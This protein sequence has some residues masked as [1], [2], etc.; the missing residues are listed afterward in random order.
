MF[1]IVIERICEPSNTKPI[2]K[3]WRPHSVELIEEVADLILAT[4]TH[5]KNFAVDLRYGWCP[6]RITF[7]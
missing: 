1:R 6:Y 2:R 5:W 3:L 7:T 4:S